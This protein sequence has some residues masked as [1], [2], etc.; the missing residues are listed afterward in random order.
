MVNV[1]PPEPEES[2]PDVYL[3][4]SDYLITNTVHIPRVGPTVPVLLL[5]LISI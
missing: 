5:L 3:L 4:V 2:S 1:T